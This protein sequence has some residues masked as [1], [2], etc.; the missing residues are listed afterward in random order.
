LFFQNVDNLKLDRLSKEI[1]TSMADR[2]VRGINWLDEKSDWSLKSLT[3][4]DQSSANVSW[5]SY[6]I[7][8]Q[9]T[10][11]KIKKFEDFNLEKAVANPDEQSVSYAE[12]MTATTLNTNLG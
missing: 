3:I 6:Y 4:G 1:K 5:V 10:R 12:Q 2:A 9:L 7:S 8:D 11:G